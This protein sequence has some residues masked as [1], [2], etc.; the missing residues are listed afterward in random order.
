MI[1]TDTV[2][3]A[4]SKDKLLLEKLRKNEY[5]TRLIQ[6]LMKHVKN[7]VKNILNIKMAKNE[8]NKGFLKEL[9]LDPQWSVLY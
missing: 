8:K 9:S 6:K 5:D 2:L 1:L 3:S 7:L 4:L